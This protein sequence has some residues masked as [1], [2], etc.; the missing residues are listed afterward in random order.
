M[1]AKP[2]EHNIVVVIR[3]GVV[4]G[5]DQGAPCVNPRVWPSTQ[6]KVS[7]N[8]QKEKGVFFDAHDEFININQELTSTIVL[9]LDDG[10]ILEMPQRIN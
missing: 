8:V 2:R 10:L 7:L 6:K 3:G 5:G 9:V 1:Y 4:T